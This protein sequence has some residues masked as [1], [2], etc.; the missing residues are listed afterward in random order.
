MDR[1]STYVN[2][3]GTFFLPS[4]ALGLLLGFGMIASRVPGTA[5]ADAGGFPTRTPTITPTRT[6]TATLEPTSIP[7]ATSTTLPTLTPIAFVSGQDQNQ[8][9]T[10]PTLQPILAQAGGGGIGCWPI[11]LFI[12][13]AVILGITYY[14]TRRTHTEEE[15]YLG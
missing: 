5:L 7:T 13:L 15:E 6:I 2:R 9:A 1:F 14:F 10:A 11:A 3:F 4:I 8:P 12:L